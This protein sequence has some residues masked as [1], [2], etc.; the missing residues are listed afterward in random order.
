[1]F[2]FDLDE[3]DAQRVGRMGELVVELNLLARGWHVGNFNATTPNSMGWDLFAI[4]GNRSVRFR[5]KAK[6]PGTTTFRW[7]ATSDRGVFPGLD[8]LADDDFVAAVSF[9]AEAPPDIYLLPSVEVARELTEN[10]RAWLA[11]FKRNGARRK[12]TSMRHLYLDARM[13]R[14]SHGYAVKWRRYRGSWDGLASHS[15]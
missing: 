12:D 14:V 11:G 6:R 9:N 5:V 3:L 8:P 7:S 2:R 1:M 15:R 4:R 10:H 13:D